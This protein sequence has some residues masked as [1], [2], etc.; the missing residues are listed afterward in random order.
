MQFADTEAGPLCVCVATSRTREAGIPHSLSTLCRTSSTNEAVERHEIG[1]QP[2]QPL[3]PVLQI[4]AADGQRVQ[5][6]GRRLRTH[7]EARQL[8]AGARSD[9]DLGRA[10]DHA[11]GSDATLAATASRSRCAW[12]FSNARTMSS[13]SSRVP[14]RSRCSS[15]APWLAA[16]GLACRAIAFGGN[17]SAVRRPVAL[18]RSERL[19]DEQRLAIQRHD[20]SGATRE[21]LRPPGLRGRLVSARPALL[22]Q[23]ETGTGGSRGACNRGRAVADGR[24]QVATSRSARYLPLRSRVSAWA[25]KRSNWALRIAPWNSPRR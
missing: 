12:T 10:D 18:V 20:V 23:A 2:Q 1:V 9:V 4:Q 24:R 13:M 15:Q 5:H 7:G 25:S 14:S 3:L 22:V 6:L 19:I 16:D 21:S 8:D 11:V 17:R